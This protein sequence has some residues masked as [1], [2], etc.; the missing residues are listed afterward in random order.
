WNHCTD[1][2]KM[3]YSIGLTASL[4]KLRLFACACCR[5]VWEYVTDER[6]RIGVQVAERYADGLASAQ[7]LA[8]AREGTGAA[9]T[10]VN[11]PVWNLAMAARSA[12]SA[13]LDDRQQF[14]RA[15]HEARGVVR[16]SVVLD[17]TSQA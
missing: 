15:R 5:R 13:C 10:A 8:T 12:H 1:A 2:D 16:W 7:E 14:L 11:G 4:R 9:F 6:S 17:P 3:L